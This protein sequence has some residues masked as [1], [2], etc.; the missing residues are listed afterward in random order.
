MSKASIEEMIQLYVNKH[1]PK[2][3][4]EYYKKLKELRVSKLKKYSDKILLNGDLMWQDQKETRDL[5]ITTLEALRYCRSLNL[6]TKKDW[7]LPSY[8]ELLTIVNYFRFDAAKIDE[9]QHIRSNQYWTS[10]PDAADISA[11]W[12]VDFKYGQ[13]GSTLREKKL[14]VR[15]V[16]DMEKEG[17][18]F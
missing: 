7:R 4:D 16:R 17:E 1:Y 12:Y 9:I 10:S 3:V 14:N 13:T 2:R 15:C 8:E 5:K 18:L 6:A 11:N